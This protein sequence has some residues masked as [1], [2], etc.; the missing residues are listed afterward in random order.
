[1]DRPFYS[2]TIGGKNTWD[3]WNLMPLNAG[4]IEFATPS[5]KYESVEVPGSDDVLDMTEVLTGYPLY[6]SRKG[7][8]KFRFFD[9][10]RSVRS[11]FNE[12]KNFLHGRRMQA[13][14]ED[15]PEYYYVGRFMV[16][17][18]EPL[19]GNWGDIEISYIL[20]AYK[21]DIV[22][23]TDDWLWDPFNFETGVI[24]EYKDIMIDFNE[25]LPVKIN[26]IG[27]P[28]PTVP[29]IKIT[30]KYL[31]GGVLDGDAY[32][33]LTV[34]E[35]TYN[36]WNVGLNT[37]T[38][39]TFPDLVLFDDEYEFSFNFTG[40]TSARSLYAKISIEFDGGSL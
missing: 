11:R 13:I 28:K 15:E 30:E 32:L 31:A 6:D 1:M 9:N 20:N 19:E 3:E 34:G 29:K 8:V 24:R 40:V 22:N 37:L 18:F 25:D 26:V 10:G 17:D 39:V 36:L 7:S 35:K 5:V 21:L 12:L 23:S 16:G 2:V 38:S 4:K 27:S 14:I 33:T